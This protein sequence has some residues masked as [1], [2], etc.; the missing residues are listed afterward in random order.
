MKNLLTFFWKKVIILPANKLKSPTLIINSW[1]E[2]KIVFK[3]I[4][5]LI[6][7]TLNIYLGNTISINKVLIEVPSYISGPIDWKGAN[8]SL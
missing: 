4:I 7:I 6:R 8:P 5:N 2:I 1:L 3:V